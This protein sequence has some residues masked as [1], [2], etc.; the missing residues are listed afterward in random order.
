MKKGALPKPFVLLFGACFFALSACTNPTV[1]S[2]SSVPFSSSKSSTSST[3]AS[4][5]SDSSSFPES[6]SNE[7]SSKESSSSAPSSSTASTS[8]S[9]P[10]SSSPSTNPIGDGYWAGIDISGNTVGNA[11]RSALQSVMIK[12][13]TKTGSNSYKEL[14]NILRNSDKHPNGGVCAFYRHD[15][16]ASSWNK[17]HVWPNSRGAGES[18][19]YAGSD[20]QVIRPTNSSDN[21][22][23]SNFMYAERQDPT[24]KA[25]AGSGWD[26]AAFGYEGARGE[27]ARIIFYAATRYYNLSTAGAGGTSHGSTPLNLAVSLDNDSSAHLMGKLDDMLRWNAKY[28]VT[29]AEIYRND[30]LGGIDYA[31]N[32]FID[33]PEWVNFIWDTTGIRSGSYTPSSSSYS[34]SSSNTPSS[35][36]SSSSS[37]TSVAPIS[38]DQNAVAILPSTSGM[39]TQ[40]PTSETT[41]TVN[42]LALNFFET[43]VYSDVIQFHKSDGY[44]LNAGAFTSKLSSIEIAVSGGSAPTVSYGDTIDLGKEAAPTGSGTY[45]Y[46]LGDAGASYF[47]MANGSANVIKASSITLHFLAA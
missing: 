10:S 12:K 31:R 17:E 4:S 21:S 41:Y 33:H 42:G 45:T 38:V 22:S 34:S 19:G 47:K 11:F 7:S 20:P 3:L 16:V 6:S 25:T 15:E 43:A 39:P 44:I 1:L 32:P 2:S 40:Y 9:Y 13:G 8:S 29:R 27:A 5:S 37:S 26:P 30:Y 23:R 28:P 46:T 24:A 14:N 35:E 36:T 18:S